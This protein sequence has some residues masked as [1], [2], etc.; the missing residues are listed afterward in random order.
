MSRDSL[1]TIQSVSEMMQEFH[2]SARTLRYYKEFGLLK[3]QRTA[4]NPR[5]LP[6]KTSNGLLV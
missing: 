2:V 5:F 4:G 6:A 3:P 1:S